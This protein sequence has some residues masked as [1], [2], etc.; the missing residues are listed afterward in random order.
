[1]ETTESPRCERYLISALV[2][3]ADHL[4]HLTESLTAAGVTIVKSEA[5]GLRKL[6]FPIAKKNELELVS[7][8]FM[9]EPKTAYDFERS[10]QRDAIVK[11]FLLTKWSVDPNAAPRSRGKKKVEVAA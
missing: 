2:E 4:S 3:S 6:A 5:L 1:M 11:R 9:A 7:V 10:L 8:F